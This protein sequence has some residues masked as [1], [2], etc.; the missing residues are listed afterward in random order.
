VS[1]FLAG[2]GISAM[3]HQPYSP[4]LATTHFSLFPELKSL[5]KERHFSDDEEGYFEKFQVPNICS[6]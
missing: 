2:K 5:L 1:Q 3:D 6:S 4:D